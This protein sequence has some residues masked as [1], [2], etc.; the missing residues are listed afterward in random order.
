M[1]TSLFFDN[2]EPLWSTNKAFEF[3]FLWTLDSDIWCAYQ[4]YPWQFCLVSFELNFWSE[5]SSNRRWR[6]PAWG[7][8]LIWATIFLG[9]Q[10]FVWTIFTPKLGS[11]T[12]WK[13]EPTCQLGPGAA[14]I[15]CKWVDW[16]WN[17]QVQK[18]ARSIIH[19]L[20]L[21]VKGW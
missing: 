3:V 14:Y 15:F 7:V 10:R 20:T 4:H 21:Y 2:Y 12:L 17:Y 11:H 19:A 18:S 8:N 13:W 9:F 1:K 16:N 5:V 6:G